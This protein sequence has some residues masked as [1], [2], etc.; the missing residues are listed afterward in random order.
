MSGRVL[1]EPASQ[2]PGSGPS[3]T[4]IA[5]DLAETALQIGREA[6]ELL[7]AGAHDVEAVATKSSSHDLVTQ[8][9]RAAEALIRDRIQA[10]R[11]GDRVL[12]EEGGEEGGDG[13]VRWIVDPLDGTVNYFYGQ[14]SWAVSIGIEVDGRPAAGVV[15]A[16]ALG[17]EYLA[18]AGEG[19]WWLGGDERHRL[20]VSQVSDLADAVVATG[21]GYIVARRRHQAQVVAGLIPQIRDIR[22]VGAAA[23]DLC[24]LARGRFDAHYER[25]LQEWD[26]AAGGLIAQ[27]AG[28]IVAGLPGKP[29]SNELLIGANPAL[30]EQLAAAL[31]EL[32]VV[33]GP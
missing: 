14:P 10:A 29:H 16:P 17:E 25:G 22:R 23:V 27:E 20:A 6:G 5:Q 12:G 15:V 3:M 28:A 30:Y 9:D 1:S 4:A 32:D 2:S 13:P 31:L 11:P 24:W 26:R 33:A 7:L 18:V 19:S 8:M 21:F